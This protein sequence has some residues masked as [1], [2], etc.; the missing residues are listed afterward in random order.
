MSAS[1]AELAFG[2]QSL[3]RVHELFISLLPPAMAK[4]AVV[5]S[6]NLNY[7]RHLK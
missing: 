3:F 5:F 7:D 6:S 2:R 1:G 4:S